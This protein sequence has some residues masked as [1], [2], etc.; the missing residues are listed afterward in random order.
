MIASA[1]AVGESRL[2][3]V[4]E[5][6][7][8]ERTRACLEACGAHIERTGD[9]AY[10]VRGLNG[11]PAGGPVDPMD[12][13]VGESGTTCRLLTGIL[14]VGLGVFRISRAAAVC[15][16]DPS[17]RSRTCSAPPRRGYRI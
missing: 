17:P 5:S 10:T 3:G 4:L 7:D 16:T 1:L 9:G 11:V 12:L 8:L 13:D 6:E 15:T 2:S 14:P